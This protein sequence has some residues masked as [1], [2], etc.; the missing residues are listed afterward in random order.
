VGVAATGRVTTDAT[1]KATWVYPNGPFP[2]VP[3][4]TATPVATTPVFVTISSVTATSVV[5]Q[6]WRLDGEPS[7]ARSVHLVAHL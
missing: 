7:T 2:L 4:V 5:V 6:A 1:G 3:V